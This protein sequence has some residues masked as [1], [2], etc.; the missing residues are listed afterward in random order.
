MQKKNIL[1][2]KNFL[3]GQN[4]EYLESNFNTCIKCINSIDLIS[5]NTKQLECLI[6]SYD[7]IIIG[8]GPQHITKK[9]IDNTYPEIINQINLIKIISKTSK[10]LLG[11]CLGCQIIAFAFGLEIIPMEKLH[12]GFG[13][14]DPSSINFNYI[15]KINDKYL[16]KLNYSLLAGSFSYHHDCIKNLKSNSI[17]NSIEQII[18]IGFSN[19]NVPYII[20]HSTANIYGFQFH[21]EITPQCIERIKT[22]LSQSNEIHNFETHSDNFETHSANSLDHKIRFHFFEIFLL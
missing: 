6:E 16:G 15:E 8:G 18:N 14:L 9:C 7:I 4:L 19:T 20:K 12:L 3:H 21:P 1:Y 13:Y 22:N 5:F 2:I 10:L 11:F 17:S